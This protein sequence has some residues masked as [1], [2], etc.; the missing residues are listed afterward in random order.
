MTYLFGFI[1]DISGSPSRSEQGQPSW[2]VLLKN[3]SQLLMHH[4]EDQFRAS[5][6]KFKVLKLFCDVDGMKHQTST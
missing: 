4:Q 1:G 3:D 2:R 6:R 5:E